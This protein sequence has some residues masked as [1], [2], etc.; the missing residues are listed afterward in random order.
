MNKA[1]ACAFATTLVVLQGVSVAVAEPLC[2]RS[3]VW[4]NGA[5]AFFQPKARRQARAAWVGVVRSDLGP[6][7]A[8]W[9]LAKNRHITC[10]RP[11]GR[12]N[13]YACTVSATP[14]RAAGPPG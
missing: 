8:K 2:S 4:A 12:Q 11:Q 3:D 6:E 9:D 10:R 1:F 13:N 7:F 14:C 5:P